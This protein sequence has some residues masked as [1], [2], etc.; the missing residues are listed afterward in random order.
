MIKVYV[1]GIPSMY[2]GEDIELRYSIFENEDVIAK[3]VVV[4]HYKKP[5][6]VGAM[7]VL[8]ALK[9]LNKYVNSEVLLL[10]ND[11]FLSE[12]IRGTNK[13]KN[14]DVQRI[15]WDIQSE[16]NKFGSLTVKDVSTDFKTLQVWN[17]ALRD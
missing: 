3:E 2:E 7:A 12:L 15:I 17:E 10:I 11:A 13:S 8:K 16:L 14:M 5:A 6:M 9:S 4:A 1:T